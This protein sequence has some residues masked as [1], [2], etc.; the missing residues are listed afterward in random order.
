MGICRNYQYADSGKLWRHEILD[1]T[2]ILFTLC[3][4]PGFIAAPP[5][6]RAAQ[7]ASGWYSSADP[8]LRN[9]K[10]FGHAGDA[11]PGARPLWQNRT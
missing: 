10:G 7:N 8:T 2:A 5:A 11:V 4:Q 9:A 1:T 6:R 3:A